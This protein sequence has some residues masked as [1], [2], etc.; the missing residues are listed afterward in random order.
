MI[1]TITTTILSGNTG[2]N[3][4]FLF[5]PEYEFPGGLSE[6][7]ETF[8]N[9]GTLV[10]ARIGT[11]RQGGETVE[12]SRKQTIITQAGVATIAYSHIEFVSRDGPFYDE[13]PQDRDAPDAE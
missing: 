9:D 10:G 2:K 3:M 11:Q 4:W 8:A 5:E 13:H 12:V 7:N 1:L 6:L